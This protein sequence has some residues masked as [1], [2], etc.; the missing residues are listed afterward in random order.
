MHLIN[1]GEKEKG[2]KRVGKENKA[3]KT[4]WGLHQLMGLES[5][6]ER[7]KKNKDGDEGQWNT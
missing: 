4:K 1:R 3:I 5:N 6:K 2:I 7:K